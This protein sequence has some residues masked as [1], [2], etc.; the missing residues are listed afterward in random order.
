MSQLVVRGFRRADVPALLGLMQGLARFEIYIDDFAVTEADLITHGLGPE[1]RFQALV[2]DDGAELLG[3][4]VLYT[5]PWTYDL[6][7]KLA[8]KELFVTRQSRG[9]GVGKALIQ[10]V[11]KRGLDI[12]ASQIIWTVLKGNIKAEQ[13]YGGLGGQRDPVWNNWRMNL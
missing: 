4:A 3:M 11:V 6:R 9:L 8:L 12:G 10:G 2:V 7:P 5:I 1:P 13:F